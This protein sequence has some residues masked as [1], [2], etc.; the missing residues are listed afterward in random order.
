MK[1]TRIENDMS[2]YFIDVAVAPT[3]RVKSLPLTLTL[4]NSLEAS[5]AVCTPGT[6]VC[7]V[8]SASSVWK[9]ILTSFMKATRKHAT[10]L[11]AITIQAISVAARSPVVMSPR[12]TSNSTIAGARHES[13]FVPTLSRNQQSSDGQ[14]DRAFNSYITQEEKTCPNAS[15]AQT[16]YH[17]ES[18]KNCN[19]K[20]FRKRW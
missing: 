1:L 5:S 20:L 11:V 6:L 10:T 15:R 14:S 9:R 13:L 17:E 12:E 8:P 19:R 4:T 3:G 16:G 7:S 2:K 18:H